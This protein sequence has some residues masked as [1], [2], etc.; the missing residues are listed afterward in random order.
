MRRV[1][2][3]ERALTLAKSWRGGEKSMSEKG[4]FEGT[5][6]REEVEGAGERDGE[7]LLGRWVGLVMVRLEVLVLGV[8]SGVVWWCWWWRWCWWEKIELFSLG[9]VDFWEACERLTAGVVMD[10]KKMG[11]VR[12]GLRWFVPAVSIHARSF[13]FWASE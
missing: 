11:L 9:E 1:E 10:G 13:C 6:E 5:E 12:G 8:V 7:A 3:E 2:R 4:R